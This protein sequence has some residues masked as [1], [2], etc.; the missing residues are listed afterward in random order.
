MLCAYYVIRPI[1]DDIGA[2]SGAENLAW[3][4]TGTLAGMLLAHPLYTTVVAK[5]TRRRFV[6]WAYRFLPS[7]SSRSISISP[8]RRPGAGDLG[9]RIFFI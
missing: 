6:S 9:G 1:R 7:T 4:F 2:A 3:L 8:Q 5:V